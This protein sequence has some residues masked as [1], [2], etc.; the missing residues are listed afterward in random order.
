MYNPQ[1]FC[2]K[3]PTNRITPRMLMEMDKKAQ[4]LQKEQLEKLAAVVTIVVG[5]VTMTFEEY[6][7]THG[8]TYYSEK[9]D[10]VNLSCGYNGGYYTIPDSSRFHEI[11]RRKAILKSDMNLCNTDEKSV[12]E[13]FINILNND[14][15]A[16]GGLLKYKNCVMDLKRQDLIQKG[17]RIHTYELNANVDPV[18]R[19]WAAK[20]LSK[21][22]S[23]IVS[24]DELFYIENEA[25]YYDKFKKTVHGVN[26]FKRG[27]KNIHPTYKV[28]KFETDENGYAIGYTV[29]DYNFYH[30]KPAE[31]VYSE[32]SKPSE[33]LSKVID[34][35]N[36]KHMAEAF[37]FGNNE[38]DYKINKAAPN[39]LNHLSNRVKIKFPKKENIKYVKFYDRN[40]RDIISRFSYYDSSTGRSLIYDIDGK[41]LYQMEYNKDDFGQIV[42]CAKF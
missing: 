26:I 20:N 25:F 31:E 33:E 5:G 38:P 14:S 36:N 24:P 21:F 11:L 1:A 6:L 27:E 19:E 12:K 39:I 2:A 28:C 17:L 40:D 37:R 18:Q 22:L 3:P 42:A 34:W 7:K 13:C 16:F 15:A 9:N 35:K 8:F 23:Y 41:Y 30:G 10:K 29:K 32:Q 4:Q